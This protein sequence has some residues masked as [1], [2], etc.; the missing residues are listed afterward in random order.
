MRRHEILFRLIRIPIEAATVFAA[1]YV[2][3]EIRLVTDLIPNVQLPIQRI[4]ESA[5]LAFAV[6]G[7]ALYVA[8]LGA[9]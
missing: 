8:V 5:L 4:S 1:F 2:A 7:S 6:S 9:F 3:R